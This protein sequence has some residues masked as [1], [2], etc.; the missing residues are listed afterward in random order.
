MKRVPEIS[1][2]NAGPA[3]ASKARQ[4]Q[5]LLIAAFIFGLNACYRKDINVAEGVREPFDHQVTSAFGAAV[6]QDRHA[7]LAE[8]KGVNGTGAV[9]ITYVG[10]ERGSERVIVNYRLPE[11]S[12]EYTLKFDVKFCEG[13]DFAKGGK[14]HGLGPLNPVG[15]GKNFDASQWSARLMFSDEGGLQTYLYHQEMRGKY[16]ESATARNFRFKPGV[17]YSIA[18]QVA[19]NSSPD[20]KNGYVRVYVDGKQL[21]EQ[22]GI[23]FRGSESPDSLISTLM[24]NTFHGGHSPDWAPREADGSYAVDCAYYDNF[25]VAPSAHKKLA[26]ANGAAQ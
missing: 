7:S 10:N 14:M 17:Y 16:G 5:I 18:Y 6:I 26:M 1:A 25:S 9:K 4:V 19:L 15:G 2:T 22:K 23:R 24:F 21:I 12:Q 11:R 20:Q 13:F 3:Y 8:G